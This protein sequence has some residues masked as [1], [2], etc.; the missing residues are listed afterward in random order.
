MQTTLIHIIDQFG[1]WGLLGLIVLENV[2]PPI[3]SE[4][5]LTFTGYLTHHTH[6]TILGSTIFATIGSV[7]GALILYAIGSWLNWERLSHLTQTRFGK[8]LRLKVS[9]FEKADRFFQKYESWA[10]LIGRF[11]PV[12]RSLISLPAGMTK[13]PL[14][15]FIWLTALGSL[16]WNFILIELGYFAG[17]AWA[18]VAD[19]MDQ[20]SAY[21]A[22]GI[23]VLIIGWIVYVVIKKKKQKN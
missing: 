17:K 21:V 12:V 2:F 11:V 19:V 3:P 4:L 20:I 22:I 6:L 9:D 7:I 18:Q 14:W 13:M 23:I 8:I 5:I 10:V 1:Y 15:R 16:I